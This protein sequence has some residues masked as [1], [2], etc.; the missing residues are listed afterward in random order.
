[1]SKNQVNKKREAREFCFQYF[2][3]LQLPVFEELKK[4]II[5]NE[6][7]ESINEFKESTNSIFSDDLNSYIFSQVKSSLSNYSKVE[8]L[9]EKYL[10]NWKL[11]RISKVDHTILMLAVNEMCFDQSTPVNIVMNEA[12]EISKKF[13]TVESGP[14]VNGILDNIAKNEL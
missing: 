11:N 10:K 13:G 12:I 3:H 4:G 2:F 7:N 5:D 9:V 6:L 8:S 1:M 14:F